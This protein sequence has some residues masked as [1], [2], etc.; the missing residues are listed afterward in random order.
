MRAFRPH[1]SAFLFQ[2]IS[3]ALVFLI[4]VSITLGVLLEPPVLLWLVPLVWLLLF[5]PSVASAYAACRKERYELHGDHLVCHRGGLLSDS[6]TELYVRNITH[7]RLR[8]PWLRHRLFGIGDVRVESAGSASS[9]ITF[10]SVV[11]PEALYAEV[12]GLMRDNGYALRGERLLHE[13]SPGV[14]GAS[15]GVLQVVAGAIGGLVAIALGVAPKLLRAG[16]VDA[17]WLTDQPLLLPGLGLVALGFLAMIAIRYLDLRRRTY[18]VYDDMV[19][20][21]EGFLTRDNALIPFENIAD[22][23]TTR[24][25]V[26][27][28]LGLYDVRVSCQGASS[29]VVFRQLQGGEAIKAAIAGL[30][31]EAGRRERSAEPEVA[32][33]TAPRGPEAGA[34]IARPGAGGVPEVLVAPEEAWTATLKM[35]LP[36]AIAGVS[37]LFIFPPVWI[38]AALMAAI[39]ATKTEYQVSAGSVSQSYAFIGSHHVQFAYDKVTG[40]QLS[41][42]PLDSL[43]KTVSVEFWSIGAPKPL[44]MNHIPEASLDLRAL[45]RQCGVPAGEGEPTVLAQSYGPKAAMVSQAP[46]LVVFAL[47][48]P[49]LLIGMIAAGPLMLVPLGIL[50]I[51]PLLRYALTALRIQV[52]RF[53]LYPDHFEAEVGLWRRRRSY[54]RYRD[55][56][57]VET[58]QLPVITQGTLSLYVAGERVVESQNGQVQVPNVVR[59]QFI[60]S[61]PRLVDAMDDLMLGRITAAEVPG[62]QAPEET[63]VSVSKPSLRNPGAITLLVGL[64]FPPLWLGLPV[65]LWKAHVRR[66]IVEGDRVLRRDGIFFKRTTSV[67]FHKLDAIQKSQGALGKAFGNGKITLLTAGSSTPD[68]VLANLPDYEAVYQSIHRRYAGS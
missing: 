67:A 64:F 50:A 46:S 57:K 12:Q 29:E 16:K 30:V 68:L 38:F 19:V 52:Q 41:R 55:I 6:Q 44:E 28:L 9:E 21:T 26:D 4:I 15:V 65:V 14:L 18:S 37:V 56:K 43:F 13:E 33:G 36:R 25:V 3:G 61:I 53:S 35:S 42:T 66:Y 5:V 62:H 34:R 49:L 59:V 32:V 58:V 48:V 11:A 17:A 47:C 54:V 1:Q 23:S 24:G 2:R 22:A 39:R 31:A 27:Q 60:A 7:V 63:P 8:L 40:V 10:T 51:I 20:Y 45:L